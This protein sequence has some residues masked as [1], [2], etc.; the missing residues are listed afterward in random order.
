VGSIARS[1]VLI[2]IADLRAGVLEAG[3]PGP[4]ER[5]IRRL[6]DSL[7][8]WGNL[9]R[10]G[11]Q[12]YGYPVLDCLFELV[13]D[14]EEDV[15]LGDAGRAAVELSLWQAV[16]DLQLDEVDRGRSAFIEKR[17]LRLQKSLESGTTKGVERLLYKW[18]ALLRPRTDKIR[19]LPGPF[20]DDVSAVVDE[21]MDA[22]LPRRAKA[23]ST[24]F[25]MPVA[26]LVRW[27]IEHRPEYEETDRT[28]NLVE[29]V[30]ALHQ[31]IPYRVLV[32]SR[33]LTRV[34]SAPL[35]SIPMAVGGSGTITIDGGTFGVIR[36]Q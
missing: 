3:G 21:L 29:R 7:V 23:L 2:N 13:A 35:G 4:M 1:D 16:G 31:P 12:F 24:K 10:S 34:L 17:R 14:I 8:A 6:C 18:A 22:G 11:R 28:R 30:T 25:Q 33:A 32:C 5:R 27:T 15:E 9:P 20:R 19:Q 36:N 26:P